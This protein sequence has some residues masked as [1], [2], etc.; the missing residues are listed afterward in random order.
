MDLNDQRIN[1][2]FAVL[3]EAAKEKKEELAKLV[4]EKYSNMR[5]ILSQTASRGQNAMNSSKANLRDAVAQGQT[6]LRESAAR[7]DVAVHENPWPYLG[8][9]AIGFGVAGF[10]LGCRSQRLY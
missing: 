8:G 7:A 6:R 3:N 5:G 9:I 2:A 4:E 10:L 1:D